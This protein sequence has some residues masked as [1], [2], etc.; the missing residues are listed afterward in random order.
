MAEYGD[1]LYHQ[2]PVSVRINKGIENVWDNKAIDA[3]MPEAERPI[4]FSRMVF[5]GDGD[6]D[7]PAMKTTTHYGGH[8]IAAS[9]LKRDP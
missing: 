5:I 8:S 4:P 3:F 1:Q 2:D 9:D 6:T 7:I